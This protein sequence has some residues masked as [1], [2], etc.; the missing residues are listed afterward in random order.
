MPVQAKS[1]PYMLAG[2]DLMI[3]SRTGS[4]KTGAFLLPIIE[5]VTPGAGTAYVGSDF[6]RAFSETR[7][8]LANGD[9]GP[10]DFLRAVCAE[11]VVEVC[12]ALDTSSQT[13]SPEER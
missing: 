12:A 3:Q 10:Q 8:F 7:D 13:L 11:R 1:I 5:R 2:R 6:A 9:T 4:G